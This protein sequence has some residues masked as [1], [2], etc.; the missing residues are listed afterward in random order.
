MTGM[1]GL[2]CF[3]LVT[4]SSHLLGQVLAWV[5]IVSSARLLLGGGDPLR[6][7]QSARERLEPVGVVGSESRFFLHFRRDGSGSLGLCRE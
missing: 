4:G 7:G 5:D 6:R 2:L 1:K 3:R